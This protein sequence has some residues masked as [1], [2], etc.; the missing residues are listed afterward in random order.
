MFGTDNAIRSAVEA[1][2][3]EAEAGGKGTSSAIRA[4]AAMKRILGD[5]PYHL[6]A[7]PYLPSATPSRMDTPVPSES[8]T[9]HMVTPMT[10]A[11]P[12]RQSTPASR[13]PSQP[14]PPVWDTPP[15]LDDWDRA[16]QLMQPPPPRPPRPPRTGLPPSHRPP[17]APLLHP[18]VFVSTARVPSCGVSWSVRLKAP[19][20][21]YREGRSNISSIQLGSDAE[22]AALPT[23]PHQCRWDKELWL[24]QGVENQE[25]RRRRFVRGD[26]KPLAILSDIAW[27]APEV[28]PIRAL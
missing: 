7:L 1:A 11:L 9:D 23:P 25:R 18:D 4:A 12:S 27:L 21:K 28:K 20:G 3:A 15:T 6:D 8:R 10:P 16:V 17:R 19:T 14:F 22:I 13:P 5:S 2:A 26:N 24:R